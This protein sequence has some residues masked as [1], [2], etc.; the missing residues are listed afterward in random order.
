MDVKSTELTFNF[1]DPPCPENIG[2]FPWSQC[3]VEM[4][5]HFLSLVFKKGLYRCYSWGLSQD[6]DGVGYVLSFPVGR[7]DYDGPGVCVL[8]DGE[9]YE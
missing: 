9:A 3:C 7:Y 8:W 5:N 6:C 2:F 1:W 4:R